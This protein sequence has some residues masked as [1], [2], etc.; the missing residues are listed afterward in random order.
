MYLH[1]F[2]TLQSSYTQQPAGIRTRD[3]I[4]LLVPKGSF[5]TPFSQKRRLDTKIHQGTFYWPGANGNT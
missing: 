4:N 1:L 3:S 5:L 2:S